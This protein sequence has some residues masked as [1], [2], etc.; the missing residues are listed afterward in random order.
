MLSLIRVAALTGILSVSVQCAVVLGERQLGELGSVAHTC[1]CTP[2][3][4]VTSATDR[5]P[6]RTDGTWAPISPITGSHIIGHP[7]KQATVFSMPL[8]THVPI[9]TTL[10]KTSSVGG[11]C[12]VVKGISEA[13]NTFTPGTGPVTVQLGNQITHTGPVPSLQLPVKGDS[14]TSTAATAP[15]DMTTPRDKRKP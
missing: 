10:G 14:V 2:F 9:D 13:G 7:T 1:A 12:T 6:L 3:T 11:S 5:Y 8:F 4:P 15:T